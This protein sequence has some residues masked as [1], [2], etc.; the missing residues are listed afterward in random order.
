MEKEELTSEKKQNKSILPK[1]DNKP[2]EQQDQRKSRALRL[3]ACSPDTDDEINLESLI[4][5]SVAHRAVTSEDYGSV[6]DT[7]GKQPRKKRRRTRSSLTSSALPA[8]RYDPA[9]APLLRTRTRTRTKQQDSAKP[10]LSTILSK[11][12]PQLLQVAQQPL[13][14]GAA[15]TLGGVSGNIGFVT[16]A[17]RLV[18]QILEG[19]ADLTDKWEDQV[20]PSSTEYNHGVQNAIVKIPG[21]KQALPP[22]ICPHCRS[23][24]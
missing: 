13:V 3:L 4:S 14:R 23:A 7:E 8:L 16:R 21:S 10:S 22:V 12:P 20:F 17:R 24:I 15:F 19:T 2:Q 5:H 1:N 9:S 6:P 18:Y 11:I